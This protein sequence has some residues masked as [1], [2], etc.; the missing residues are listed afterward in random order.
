MGFARDLACEMA[1]KPREALV[2]LKAH[3]VGELRAQIPAIVERELALHA[4]TFHQPEV[5]ERIQTTFGV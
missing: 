1:E 3:L 2:N 4:M 5:K